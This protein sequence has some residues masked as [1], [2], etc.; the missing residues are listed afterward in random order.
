[1]T[2]ILIVEDDESMRILLEVKLKNNYEIFTANN[3]KQAL[4]L[5]ENI[6]IDLMLVDV[7]MPEMNGYE[8]IRTI[9]NEKNEI[10]A[11]MITAKNA[12][13]DKLKGFE[14]GI[15]DYMT[16]PIDFDELKARIK[17]LL[18]RSRINKEK[19][20]KIGDVSINSETYSIRKGKEIIYL[21]QKEFLLLYQL[22]SY[23]EII[24]TKEQLL[25]DVWGM[26]S[27]SDETTIRTHMN[28]LR[29]KIDHFE[30][31]KIHTVRGIGYKGEII[32]NETK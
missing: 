9:R 12:I 24:F 20:I 15:D 17:V 10:P 26:N 32:E 16:K 19:E 23:P 5:L 1:M 2:K 3:G 6:K 22:L 21:P 27:E 7:M 25:D 8:L 18:R 30:E 13:T 14:S 29:N 31:F 4:K 11:I 28:R